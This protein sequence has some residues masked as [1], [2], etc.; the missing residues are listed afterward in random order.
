M[1]MD[2]ASGKAEKLEMKGKFDKAAL[3][4]LE[5]GFK[6]KA[7]S[8]Y[9]KGTYYQKA[10]DIYAEIGKLEDAERCKGKLKKSNSYETWEDE[11]HSFQQDQGNPY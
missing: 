11:Q 8:A 6:E 9:E 10:V 5:A 4:Y 3:L 2:D 7:A 1:G